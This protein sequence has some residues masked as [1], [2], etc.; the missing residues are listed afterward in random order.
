MRKFIHFKRGSIHLSRLNRHRE[1]VYL[2][3]SK[4]FSML[5]GYNGPVVKGIFDNLQT[6]VIL[7]VCDKR[8]AV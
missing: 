5:S 2:G 7:K 1:Q 4:T 3:N 8:L 6:K